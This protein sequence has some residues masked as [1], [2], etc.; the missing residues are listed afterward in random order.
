MR[1][2]TA[3]RIAT[4]AITIAATAALSLGISSEA[5]AK[6]P[7]TDWD[8]QSPTATSTS[9]TSLSGGVIISRSTDWD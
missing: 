6:K 5:W 9:S 7:S 3:R 4:A 2:S 8:L 1:H